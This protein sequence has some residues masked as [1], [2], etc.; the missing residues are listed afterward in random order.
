MRGVV[1]KTG[2]FMALSACLILA[3]TLGFATVGDRMTQDPG[4][5]IAA[6]DNC[7]PCTK[8]G[9]LHPITLGHLDACDN[10][11]SGIVL[12]AAK[13]AKPVLL[14]ESVLQPDFL[15]AEGTI[16]DGPRRPPRLVLS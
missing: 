5:W 6:N 8:Q 4:R 1:G 2:T 10:D 13:G 12:L 11:R 15:A 3:L 14:A 9:H 16:R 7:D